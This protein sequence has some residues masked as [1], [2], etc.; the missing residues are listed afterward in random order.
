[1]KTKIAFLSLLFAVAIGF[2]ACEKPERVITFEQLPATAQQFVNQ[3]FAN[4]EIAYI[5]ED[6]STLDHSYTVQFLNNYEIE[7]D[8]DGEWTEVD[9]VRDSVP[10]AIVPAAI[11]AY[12]TQHFAQQFVVKIS[13]EHRKYEVKLNTSLELVFDRKGNFKYI[14]D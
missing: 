2:V 7:F 14:D 12:V 6:P 11:T 5:I 1:M 8:G 10:I 4:C 9:C 3:H 13:Y